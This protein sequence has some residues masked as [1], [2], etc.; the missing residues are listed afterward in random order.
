M[1]PKN[2]VSIVKAFK[3]ANP[4]KLN[5]KLLL[6]YHRKT[7]M[8]YSG[9]IHRTPPNKSF[10]NFIVDLHDKFVKEMIERGYNHNS[11][12]KKI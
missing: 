4:S 8:L 11:P 12:L 6:E 2:F 10:I 3:D 9:N 7:H 1:L 5:N